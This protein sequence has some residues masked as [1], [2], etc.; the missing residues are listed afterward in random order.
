[1]LRRAF[2]YVRILALTLLM[3]GAAV[4]YLWSQKDDPRFYKFLQ[5]GPGRALA[6]TF[7]WHALPMDQVVREKPPGEM[8]PEEMQVKQKLEAEMA[9]H[10][11]THQVELTNGQILTGALVEEQP[12]YVVFRQSYG[13][14]AEVDMKLNR[15]RIAKLGPYTVRLPP[16]TYRDVRFKMEFPDMSFYKAQPYSFLTDES[17]F[18]VTHAV[19]DLQILHNQFRDVFSPL[20]D[21]TLEHHDI[22]VLFFSNENKYRSYQRQ[23]SG[24]LEYAVGFYT[25]VNDRLVVFNQFHGEDMAAI[26]RM[27]SDREAQYRAS[28]NSPDA[29]Q[30]IAEWRKKEDQRLAGYA[31]AQTKATIRHEG[32]H[33]L[34]FTYGVHSRHRVENDWL[35][36]GLACY[37]ETPQIGQI[38]PGRLRM[39]KAALQNGHA[40]PLRTLLV[41]RDGFADMGTDERVSL[42]YSQSWSLIYFLMQRENRPRFFAYIRYLREPIN[43]EAIRKREPLDLL[44]ETEGWSAPE[45]ERRW[46]EFI[47]ALPL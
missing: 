21:R 36:E 45:L 16:V 35:I 20:L 43:L 10:V 39:V 31:E 40:Y 30:R 46:K 12:D 32:S 14:A 29:E 28:A 3:S 2:Y 1:M 6:R 41:A 13:G 5:T 4:L 15:S 11:P 27:V 8:T 38:D 33:Q 19:N 26:Q 24:G 7:K 34:F 9:A 18:S 37:C 23:V 47:L 44:A 25:P 42:A 17:Y 22:E